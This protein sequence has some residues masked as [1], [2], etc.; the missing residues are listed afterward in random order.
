GALA[1]VDAARVV[2]DGSSL[3]DRALTMRTVSDPRSRPSDLLSP[4]HVRPLAVS[5][6]ELLVRAS[7]AGA[8]LELASIAGRQRST[9]LSVV[10]GQSG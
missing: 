6:D 2:G 7:P 5:P 9:A 1:S 4:G 10:V 3:A 8:A